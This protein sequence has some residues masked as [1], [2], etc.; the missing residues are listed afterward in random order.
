LLAEWRE[1]DLVE[2]EGFVEYRA[3]GEAPNVPM[4]VL[5]A[6]QADP[7]QPGAPFPATTNDTFGPLSNS[8]SSTSED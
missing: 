4:V 1:A 3:A 8:V 2:R 6:A 5:L 7:I